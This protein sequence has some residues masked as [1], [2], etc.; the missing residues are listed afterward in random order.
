MIKKFNL[1]IYFAFLFVIVFFVSPALALGVNDFLYSVELVTPDSAANQ[2]YMA[3][4]GV[5]IAKRAGADF[6]DLRVL[7]SESAE[8]PFVILNDF[9]PPEYIHNFFSMKV[10]DYSDGTD[11]AV[12]VT[13]MPDK[14]NPVEIIELDINNRDFKK[15]VGVYGSNDKAEWHKLIEE[16]VFDFSSQVNYRKTEFRLG[17]KCDFAYYKFVINNS[18]PQSGVS[19][20]SIKL[21]YDGLDFSVDNFREEKLKING[22]Y[23]KTAFNVKKDGTTV[24]DECVFDNLNITSDKNNN[25]VIDIEAELYFDRVI[26]DIA[27]SFYRRNIKVYCSETA[28]AD[29]YRY[30]TEF[31][32]YNIPLGEY[33]SSRSDLWYSSSKHRF[34]RF[35]IENKNSPPLTVNK[36]KFAMVRKN[37]FF[38]AP[39]HSPA[40]YICMGSAALKKPDYDITSFINQGNWYKLNYKTLS[41]GPLSLNAAYKEETP[42]KPMRPEVEKALLSVIMIII[43]AA[44]GYWLFNLISSVPPSG[45]SGGKDEESGGKNED[46]GDKK[47]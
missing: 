39:S 17:R 12:L 10:V 44:L 3:P 41:P 14:R 9:T 43:V 24:Y 28:A 4:L 22:V 47:E 20:Q 8:V 35:V 32:V 42:P 2:I 45:E 34:F 38:T 21:K 6:Y 36:I 11:S 46:G 18:A 40:H 31:T 1:S 30:L 33:N 5:D 15:Q 25:S 13:Q 16:P 37:L 19:G 7:N 27:P 23:A 26:F 29:S